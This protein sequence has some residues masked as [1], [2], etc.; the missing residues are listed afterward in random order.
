MLACELMAQQVTYRLTMTPDHWKGTLNSVIYSSD[1]ALPRVVDML[2][3]P[4]FSTRT[5]NQNEIRGYMIMGS[6]GQA[7]SL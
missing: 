5:P 7:C 4:A 6:P 3:A 2:V 1:T